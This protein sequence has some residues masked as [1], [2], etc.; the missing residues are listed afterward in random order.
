MKQYTCLVQFWAFSHNSSARCKNCFTPIFTLRLHEA[1]WHCENPTAH[2]NP[3]Y[4]SGIHLFWA[5]TNFGHHVIIFFLDCKNDNVRCE[6]SW[7]RR[8]KCSRNVAANVEFVAINPNFPFAKLRILS[9]SRPTIIGVQKVLGTRIHEQKVLLKTYMRTSGDVHW[10][11]TLF[12]FYLSEVKKINYPV[13]LKCQELIFWR[14]DFAALKTRSVVFVWLQWEPLNRGGRSL[15]WRLLETWA[16][17]PWEYW[18]SRSSQRP[19]SWA[20]NE[21][22]KKKK[23]SLLILKIN[24]NTARKN[25]FEGKQDLRT[26]NQTERQQT[27]MY[28]KKTAQKIVKNSSGTWSYLWPFC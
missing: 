18:S 19:S 22:W 14:Q 11:V 24:L 3:P 4:V 28:D 17:S 23:K 15:P 26:S 2:L 9:L 13:S 5:G 1:V 20:K 12:V 8:E 7:A 21:K 16:W 25:V 10:R 27:Q 6:E